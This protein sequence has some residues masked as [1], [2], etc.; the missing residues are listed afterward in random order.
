M[1]LH[2][3]YNLSIDHMHQNHKQLVELV[4]LN[5]LNFHMDRKAL[6]LVSV[7]GKLHGKQLQLHL[8]PLTNLA[9]QKSGCTF[10]H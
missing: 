3:C 4:S 6:I 5:S 9:V 10:Q 2:Y 8:L 1:N 7:E